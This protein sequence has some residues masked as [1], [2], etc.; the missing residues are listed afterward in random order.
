MYITMHSYMMN[1]FK[2]GFTLIELLIVIGILAIL[3][4]VIVVAI[5]PAEFIAQSRDSQRRNDLKAIKIA[6]TTYISHVPAL[7]LGVCPA[8]GRCTF[9]PNHRPFESAIACAVTMDN[10]VAGSGWVDVNL[11]SIPGGFPMPSLPIDPVNNANF[12]Y[13]YACRETVSPVFTFELN[14][15]L[16]SA[17]FR[18]EMA[19]DGG[20]RNC[21]CGS[22][23]VACDRSNIHLMT[24]AQSVAADCFYEIGTAPGLSL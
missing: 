6:L 4:V 2:K 3:T 10:G 21:L 15:R 1:N 13:A 11:R 19:L 22:S 12:F 5:N 18:G 24:V 9:A 14:T 16:E 8:G 23:A 7:D 20:N 17:R